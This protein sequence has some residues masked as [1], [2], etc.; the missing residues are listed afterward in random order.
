MVIKVDS[1]LPKRSR[2]GDVAARLNSDCI[3]CA[4]GAADTAAVAPPGV[5]HGL[6]VCSAV[7]YGAEL[8]DAHALPAAVALAGIDSGDVFRPVHN[9]DSLRHRAA[10][11]NAVRAVAVAHSRDKG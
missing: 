10:H 7:S 1:F 2:N 8:A 5:Y 11:G 4:N 9:R 6:F 3:F